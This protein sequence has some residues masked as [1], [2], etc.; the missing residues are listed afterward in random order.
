MQQV[1][2]DEHVEAR[3][4]SERHGIVDEELDRHHDL[5]IGGPEVL[6]ERVTRFEQGDV[7]HAE[8]AD[9][10]EPGGGHGAN[11]GHRPDGRGHGKREPGGQ[12][13]AD[14]RVQL[15]HWVH[16][17]EIPIGAE[18]GQREH[19]HADRNVFGRLRYLANGQS[20]RPRRELCLDKRTRIFLLH[21]IVRFSKSVQ[22]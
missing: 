8:L 19:R 21:H 18:R 16:D 10:R 9:V 4:D 6:G 20:V 12:P 17:G 1:P 5:G 15:S 22:P 11:H 7:V 13:S 3:D 2:S 14:G